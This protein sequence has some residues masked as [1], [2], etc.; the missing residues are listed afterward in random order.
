MEFLNCPTGEQRRR[1]DSHELLAII[2][3][4]IKGHETG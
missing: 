4:V 3:A 1:K 2:E